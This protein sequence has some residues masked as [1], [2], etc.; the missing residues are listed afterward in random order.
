ME[1][2]NIITELKPIFLR[3]LDIEKIDLTMETTAADVDEWDSLAQIL[4]ITEIEKHFRIKFSSSEVRD[5][6]N[7]GQMVNDILKRIKN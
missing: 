4:L 5:W 3:V 6:K 1:T 2:N 7:V